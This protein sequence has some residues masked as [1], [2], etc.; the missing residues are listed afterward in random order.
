MNQQYPQYPQQPY[1][2]QMPQ[3]PQSPKKRGVGKVVGVGC[4]GLLALFVIIGVVAGGGD[5]GDNGGKDKTAAA[6]DGKEKSDPQPAEEV[7]AQGPVKVTAKKTAFA[8][9]ILADG[10]DYTS[11]LVTVANNGGEQVDVNP[12]YFTITDTDGTKHTAELAVDENQIDTVKLASGENV[13]GAVTGKGTFTPKY[14]TFTD[15]L[16]GDPVR[17]DVS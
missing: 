16:F 11:V 12:L 15:G 7:R 8:Q 10:T 13:S 9:T 2:P 1:P 4:A 6:A 3:M 17:V 5:S 14:V